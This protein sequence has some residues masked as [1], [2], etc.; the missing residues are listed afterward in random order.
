MLVLGRECFICEST[1]KIY[2]MRHFDPALGTAKNILIVNAAI[3]YD[4]QFSH[5]T[6]ILIVC[7][8]T[9][10]YASLNIYLHLGLI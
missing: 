6:Y 1:G 4:C 3:A 9:L 2:N 5:D 10:T 8:T 7:K